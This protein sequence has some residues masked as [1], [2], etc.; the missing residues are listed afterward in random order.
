MGRPSDGDVLARAGAGSAGRVLVRDDLG[1]VCVAVVDTNGDEAFVVAVVLHLDDDGVWRESEWN[2]AAVLGRGWLDGV[3][4]AYGRTASASTVRIG[5]GDAV[6]QVPVNG[7]GWWCF[8]AEA[9][10]SERLDLTAVPH[11]FPD[12]PPDQGP[13]RIAG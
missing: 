3:A 6:R 9:P 12:A 10:Q 13:P 5:V 8:M 11:P 7:P 4:Y 2:S 1:R